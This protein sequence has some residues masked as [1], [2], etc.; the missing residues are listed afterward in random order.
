MTPGGRCS[1]SPTPPDPS[2][3]FLLWDFSYLHDLVSNLQPSNFSRA[4]F[5]YPCD[6][7][8]LGRDSPVQ[9]L[10]S[11]DW[12]LI[13]RAKPSTA[14]SQLSICPSRTKP[15]PNPQARMLQPLLLLSHV[16]TGFPRAGR[17]TPHPYPYL[18]PP[19]HFLDLLRENYLREMRSAPSTKAQ[20]AETSPQAS[21]C[22]E[23][24][25][26]TPLPCLSYLRRKGS[27]RDPGQFHLQ[28]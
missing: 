14:Y 12:P 7:N 18:L 25:G 3:V 4:S 9:A 1:P 13:H 11:L 19:G 24:S 8:T 20:E 27:G 10:G 6:V 21:L 2:L 22:R 17:P 15:T 16:R 5:R 23:V 26:P 28:C